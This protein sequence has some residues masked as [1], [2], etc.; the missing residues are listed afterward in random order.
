MIEHF[1]C[2]R[3]RFWWY[4]YL[5]AQWGWRDDHCPFSPQI[6][7]EALMRR[8]SSR[9]WKKTFWPYEVSKSLTIYPFGKLPT[10]GQ[11]ISVQ[12][13]NIKV[14][15]LHNGLKIWFRLNHSPGAILNS[16][17]HSLCLHQSILT[18]TVWDWTPLT[19]FLTPGDQLILWKIPYITPVVYHSSVVRAVGTHYTSIHWNN[20]RSTTDFW[21][22]QKCQSQNPV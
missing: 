22:M 1:C 5:R 9:H 11:L 15:C 19:I 18:L 21:K 12:S 2:C 14:N 20:R 10:F 6:I 16:N 3:S 4:M 13:R 8:K 7:S 17:K